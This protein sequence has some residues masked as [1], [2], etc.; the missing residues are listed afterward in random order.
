MGHNNVVRIATDEVGGRDGAF[1]P[2]F[3]NIDDAGAGDNTLVAAVVGKKL[4][5][6]SMF[7]VASGGVNIYFVDGNNTTL[8]GGATNK[9]ALTT[10][11]GFSLPYNPVGWFET[12]AGFSLD[13]NLS[14]ATAVA[15]SL[16]YIEV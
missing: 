8:A 15:G 16:T 12:G 4:R 13:V 6:V 5:V 14:A 9:I 11:S 3:A 10:N 2:M 1:T 7:V